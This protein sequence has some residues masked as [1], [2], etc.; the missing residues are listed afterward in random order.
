MWFEWI[1][2]GGPLFWGASI[3]EIIILIAC[4]EH[5]YAGTSAISLVV[6]LALLYLF[7]N[8]HLIFY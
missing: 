5:E 2:F 6:F 7:G 4:I 8:L 3:I 1:L